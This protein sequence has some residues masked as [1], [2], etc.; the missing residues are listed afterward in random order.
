MAWSCE[1]EEIARGQASVR[2][3]SRGGAGGEEFLLKGGTGLTQ[4]RE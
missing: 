2:M 3:S 1:G 4:G